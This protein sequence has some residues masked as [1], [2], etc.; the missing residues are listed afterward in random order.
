MTIQQFMSTIKR[1]IVL[2]IG[3]IVLGLSM[4]AGLSLFVITPIY[5]AEAQILVNQKNEGTEA[6]TW[7]KTQ[8]DLRLINTYNVI[9]TSPAILTKVIE[10][11]NLTQTPEELTE[12]ITVSSEN[13]SKVVNIRVAHEEAA[14]AVVISNTLAEVFQKEV[15]KLM[16][17]DNI[18]I[19]STAEMEASTI[20]VTP[21]LWLN[22]L[23]ALV[24][25][26]MLGVLVAL[27]LEI[28]DTTLKN[29]LDVE[30]V[31]ELPVMG[32]ISSMKK[33]KKIRG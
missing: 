10:Q 23:I 6:Y 5:E 20:P 8:A 4:A 17:V 30:E 15:P 29:E 2:I 26:I 28:L 7:D 9:I 14:Q 16:A 27:F 31:L 21:K 1:R 24:G 3:I 22:L 12:K 33:V 19:L 13:E 25:S 18:T 32:T 11:L